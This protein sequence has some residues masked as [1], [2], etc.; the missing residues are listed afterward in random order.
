MRTKQQN[1]HLIQRL[2]E[3]NGVSGF[4]DEVIEIAFDVLSSMNPTVDF[5]NN[6]YVNLGSKDSHRP[7]IWLDAHSDEIGFMI[8]AINPNGTMQILPIGGW[9]PSNVIGS[10]VRVR[11]RQGKYIPGIVATKP[12]HFK[13]EVDTHLGTTFSHLVLD[14]GASSE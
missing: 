8:Q 10:R 1:I 11:N 5:I 12:V 6:L 4:E 13:N 14:V 2:S 3:A 7:K 9:D